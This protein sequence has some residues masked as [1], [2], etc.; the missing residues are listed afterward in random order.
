MENAA[1]FLDAAD[2]GLHV[3]LDERTEHEA[4]MAYY[5]DAGDAR[6]TLSGWRWP[7]R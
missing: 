3:M 2:T 1:H 5:N 6:R 4:E 7:I